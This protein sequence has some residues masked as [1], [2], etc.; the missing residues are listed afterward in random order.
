MKYCNMVW[1]YYKGIRWTTYNAPQVDEVSQ[2]T[3]VA[4][5]ALYPVLELLK[6]VLVA[7]KAK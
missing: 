5:G 1:L 2:V 7:E 3:Q 4:P 6:D